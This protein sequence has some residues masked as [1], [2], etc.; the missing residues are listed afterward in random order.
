MAGI[1]ALQESHAAIG[2]EKIEE[3]NQKQLRAITEA[4]NKGPRTFWTYIPSL[5]R[6]PIIP[7]LRDST[8]A[9]VTD[10]EEHLVT[11]L[12]RLTRT[13]RQNNRE[14]H[15]NL[16]EKT[17]RWTTGPLRSTSGRC[18]VWQSTELCPALE[19]TAPQDWMKFHLKQLGQRAR[20]SLASFFT[21]ILNEEP[22]PEDWRCSKKCLVL[23]RGGNSDQL[24]DYR[25]LTVTSVLY[26]LFTQLIKRSMSGWTETQEPFTE[27]QMASIVSG[28]GGIIS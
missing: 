27:L 16:V 8:G 13:R 1:L 22:I 7:T 28:K 2:P 14:C 3:S 23:M 21:G 12:Q 18:P 19:P 5:N 4:G 25:P 11:Y 20:E 15:T 9:A 10:L 26:Q 17:V 6:E 24:Q